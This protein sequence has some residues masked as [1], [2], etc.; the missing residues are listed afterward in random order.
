MLGAFL[1]VNGDPM[2][3]PESQTLP[4]KA[5]WQE[6]TNVE[7]KSCH[8][9]EVWDWV[10]PEEVPEGAEIVSSRMVYTKKINKDNALNRYK[11][12]IVARDMFREINFNDTFS[13]TAHPVSVRALVSLSMIKGWSLKTS[14]VKTA[15][16]NAV[17]DNT[18]Y[19]HPPKGLG[20][21]K[22]LL[23]LK[24]CLYG[25]KISAKRWH[26]TVVANVKAFG[27]TAVT[28]DD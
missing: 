7:L 10:D 13:P 1:T 22:K 20:R 3:Y 2:D 28:S 24:K 16:L 27:M 26:E 14:D 17:L 19:M 12:R 15:Y 9:H 5:K 11:A 8:D 23:H 21:G 18:V 4:D 25:L 6:A